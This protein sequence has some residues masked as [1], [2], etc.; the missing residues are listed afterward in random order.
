[1]EESFLD[2]FF[3]FGLSQTIFF[4][5][6]IFILPKDILSQYEAQNRLHLIAKP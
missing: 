2:F 3:G 6:A 5:E 4:L 1:L